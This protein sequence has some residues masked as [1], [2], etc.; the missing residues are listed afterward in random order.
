MSAYD[1]DG[2][3]SSPAWNKLGEHH[4]LIGETHLRDFFE[5]EPNRATEFTAEGAGLF[6]DYSK[7]RVNKDT[8]ALLLELARQRDLEA[9]R[10]AMFR[11][12]TST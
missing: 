5:Q 4:Q 2:L 12:S 9:R 10:E 1:P 6:M 8:I 11:A 7:Q 3:T